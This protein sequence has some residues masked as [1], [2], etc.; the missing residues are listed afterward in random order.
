M[1]NAHEKVPETGAREIKKSEM[2]R[3]RKINRCQDI[4]SFPTS[5]RRE[6]YVAAGID[7]FN[8]H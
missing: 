6:S 1:Y 2:R 8:Q 3:E 5:N 4:I 7:K